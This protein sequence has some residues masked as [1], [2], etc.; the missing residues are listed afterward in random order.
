MAVVGYDHRDARLA[1]KL[2]DERIY[3]L[4]FT[5]A[6]VLQFKVEVLLAEYLAVTE[7]CFLRALI[8]T[9]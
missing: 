6:V 8:V 3:I 4:L 1:G 2:Y 5:D 7:S 9:V